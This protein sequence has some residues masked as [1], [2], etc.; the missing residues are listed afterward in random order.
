MHHIKGYII[1]RRQSHFFGLSCGISI[2]Q[3]VYVAVTGRNRT[4]FV[5]AIVTLPIQ[6]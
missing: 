6:R 3:P 5:H 1:I 4:L 2:T